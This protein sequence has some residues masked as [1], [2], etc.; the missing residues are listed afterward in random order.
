MDKFPEATPAQ[1]GVCARTEQA[2]QQKK[3]IC[4]ECK[5]LGFKSNVF[6][7]IDRRN[8]PSV[9]EEYWDEEGRHHL[10][11]AHSENTYG[12]TNK[13]QWQ[14]PSVGDPCW[15]GWPDKPDKE[16]E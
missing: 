10:H 9:T 14:P 12:C 5:A 7:L 11:V 16:E 15:C 2:K 6:L 13:H 8:D 3:I 1:R 4:P